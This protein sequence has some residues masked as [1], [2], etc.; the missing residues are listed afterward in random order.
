MISDGCCW[1]DLTFLLRDNVVV[2]YRLSKRDWQTA[3][4]IRGP[5]SDVHCTY[6]TLVKITKEE[7][8]EKGKITNEC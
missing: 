5:R 2:R 4:G 1:D 3:C 8:E 6:I 7:E